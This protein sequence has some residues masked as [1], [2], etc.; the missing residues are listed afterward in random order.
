MIKRLWYFIRYHTEQRFDWWIVGDQ[1]RFFG[2]C[3]RSYK[4]WISG[5]KE[6]TDN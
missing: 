5:L 6:S 3:P 2:P 4:D 1:E